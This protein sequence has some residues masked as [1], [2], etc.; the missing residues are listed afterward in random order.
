MCKFSKKAAQQH[1]KCGKTFDITRNIEG[2]HE[3]AEELKVFIEEDGEIIEGDE[4]DAERRAAEIDKTIKSYNRRQGLTNFPIT[5]RDL[6]RNIPVLHSK[7]KVWCLLKIVSDN[8][9]DSGSHFR[10]L[11]LS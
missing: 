1:A 6:C 11:S 7:I 8:I 5:Y 4:E 2:L 3:L 10:Y 9:N